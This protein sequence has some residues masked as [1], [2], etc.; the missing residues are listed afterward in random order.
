MDSRGDRR[1]PTKR[2]GDARASLRQAGGGPLAARRRPPDGPGA[3][4]HRAVMA[5]RRIADVRPEM[6]TAERA[7]AGRVMGWVRSLGKA[8]ARTIRGGCARDLLTLSRSPAPRRRRRADRCPNR[9]GCPSHARLPPCPIPPRTGSG[10]GQSA[11][12]VW[13]RVPASWPLGE[14]AMRKSAPTGNP[15]RDPSSRGRRW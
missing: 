7:S 13:I 4:E 14:G 9:A 15:Q 5:I 12:R 6:V 3:G 11:T 1:L 2:S 10:R 8:V